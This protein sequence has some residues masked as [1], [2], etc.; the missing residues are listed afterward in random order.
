V[1]EQER[2]NIRRHDRAEAFLLLVAEALERGFSVTATESELNE[3]ETHD[4]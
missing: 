4:V 3:I 1:I 2:K